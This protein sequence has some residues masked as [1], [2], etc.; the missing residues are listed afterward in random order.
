[1]H[2]TNKDYLHYITKKKKKKKKAVNYKNSE[3]FN[4]NK[5]D[6]AYHMSSLTV[7][8][9][10]FILFGISIAHNIR[11]DANHNVNWQFQAVRMKQQTLLSKVLLVYQLWILRLSIR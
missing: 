8:K 11:G 10:H 5:K 3:H 6:K 9:M 1:M 7:I 2:F 4:I